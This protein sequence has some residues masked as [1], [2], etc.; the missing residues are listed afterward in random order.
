MEEISAELLEKGYR[1]AVIIGV[2]MA[3]SVFVYLLVAEIIA[4]QQVDFSGFSPLPHDTFS[5][6]RLI[7]FVVAGVGFA[8]IPFIAKLA[9]SGTVTNS[10]G[11]ALPEPVSRLLSSALVSYSLCETSAIFGLI[12]FLTNGSRT[13]LYTFAAISLIAYIVHFPRIGRWR[14]ALEEKGFLLRP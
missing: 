9:S 13:D 5:R 3:A 11:I 2:V 14:G 1:R 4:R 8:A 12:L 6:L 7:F 10:G